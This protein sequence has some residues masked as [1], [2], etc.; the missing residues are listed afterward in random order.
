MAT[1]VDLLSKKKRQKTKSDLVQIKN[2]VECGIEKKFSTQLALLHTYLR[3]LLANEKF[4]EKMPLVTF[5]HWYVDN[6]NPENEKNRVS[7]LGEKPI[8]SF[9]LT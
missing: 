1:V 9:L 4:P 6:L 5:F 8:L 7:P 3:L 2:Q